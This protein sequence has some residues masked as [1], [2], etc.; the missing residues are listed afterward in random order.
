MTTRKLAFL[1]LA[2]CLLVSGKNVS[3]QLIFSNDFED[4]SFG[5]YTRANLDAD[6]NSPSGS[7]GVED[8]GPGTARTSIVSDGTGGKALQVQI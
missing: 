5:T 8:T 2:C 1:V 6:W 7:N 3:A 4:D